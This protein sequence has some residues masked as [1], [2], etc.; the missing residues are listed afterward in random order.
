[1]GQNLINQTDSTPSNSSPAPTASSSPSNSG[2]NTPIYLQAAS[3]GFLALLMAMVENAESVQDLVANGEMFL[4]EQ[5]SQET[6]SYST[7]WLTEMSNPNGSGNPPGSTAPGTNPGTN[8]GDTW[9]LA[10]FKAN[11]AWPQTLPPNA[12]P[13]STPDTYWY[14][15]L[16]DIG[17]LTYDSL[18]QFS[19]NQGQS[20]IIQE[21]VTKYNLDNTEYNQMT[22]FFSGITSGLSDTIN[23]T[24]NQVSLDYQQIQLNTLAVQQTL[25]QV[26]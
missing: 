22:S 8:P 3:V 20:G 1:M 14:G 18:S 10:Y 19:G 12:P 13:G 2:G 26:L 23:N 24:N 21:D 9:L 11:N 15:Q 16:S 17:K 5:V 25:V 6:Q 4:S 7:A